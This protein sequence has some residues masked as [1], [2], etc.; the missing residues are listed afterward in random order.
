VVDHPIPLLRLDGVCAGYG[1]TMILEDVSLTLFPGDAV[2]VLGRNG[3]GK[4]T[5]LATIM[6]HTTLH[7]GS[8]AFQGDDIS[9]E[10]PFRRSWRGLGLVPQT[11]RIFP[12]L[13]VAENLD[14]ARRPGHWTME[15]IYELFP[16]LAE[17]RRNMGNHLSGGEQQMLA[18][19]RALIGN[20]LLM[21][22]DEP[23]EGLAPVIIDELA[24]MLN[25]LRA[26]GEP[27]T[28]L[29]EQY[30]RLALNL[31]DQAVVLDRGRV[32]YHG[33]SRALLDDVSRLDNLIGITAGPPQA[34]L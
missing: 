4:T 15:A 10:A 32:V 30:T 25:G 17:R 28:L 7:R 31:T 11:R 18:I 27:A 6:G 12:S 22:M 8:L 29:V 3:V 21:L 34:K 26:A 14:V 13:T 16:R 2:A 9:R 24:H 1:P 20:P 23:F 5:L 33:G 19:G